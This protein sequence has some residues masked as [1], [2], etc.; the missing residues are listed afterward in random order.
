MIILH[1]VFC[2]HCSTIE[3]ESELSRNKHRTT[4]TNYQHICTFIGTHDGETESGDD[5]NGQ[6]AGDQVGRPC[7]SRGP[8]GSHEPEGSQGPI[9]SVAY[10]FIILHV[11]CLIFSSRYDEDA[12]SHLLHS[13]DW[14]NLQGTTEDTIC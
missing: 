1:Q 12:K 14:M 8:R 13:N 4:Y 10:V 9:G 7:T 11:K 5:I 3:G 6:V 2:D